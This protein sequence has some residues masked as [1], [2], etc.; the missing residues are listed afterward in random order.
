[1]LRPSASNKLVIPTFL[2]IIPDM[3]L[4][5]LLT[6]IEAVGL[7][8]RHSFPQRDGK[9]RKDYLSIK[10]LGNYFLG[11]AWP[12]MGT[13]HA[14]RISCGKGLFNGSVAPALRDLRRLGDFFFVIFRLCRRLGDFFL[15]K[16]FVS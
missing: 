10:H 3:L 1:M 15:R 2:P 13:G 7:R 9:D 5:N 4:I 14:P 12:A 11:L 16:L 6:S 8:S